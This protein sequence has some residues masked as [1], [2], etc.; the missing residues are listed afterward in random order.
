MLNEWLINR[1][2]II[3]LI[4]ANIEL[5][6]SGFQHS[7]QL[8]LFL[9]LHVILLIC[10]FVVLVFVISSLIV[11]FLTAKIYFVL[12]NFRWIILNSFMLPIDKSRTSRCFLIKFRTL[13]NFKVLSARYFFY[14]FHLLLYQTMFLRRIVFICSH[15][16][17][18]SWWN[19]FDF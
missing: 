4:T 2:F 1:C 18:L 8:V 13:S 16:L 7:F 19:M 5:G 3:N 6:S 12:V 11:K 14:R 10:L 15:V 9:A 17:V